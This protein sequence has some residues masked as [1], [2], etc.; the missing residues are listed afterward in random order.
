M[1]K[2]AIITFI[3][4]IL[5]L[6][7]LIFVSLNLGSI[8][9]TYSELFKGLFIEY[10]EKVASIYNIRFPRIFLCLLSGA[11]LSVSGVLFQTILKNPIADA[12][13][14]GVAS[15]ASLATV[16]ILTIFPTLFFLKPI[17]AF[18]GGIL[19]F[20]LILFLSFGK[21]LS[22]IK[23]I[24]IGIAINSCFSGIIECFSSMNSS[25]SSAISSNVSFKTWDDV[26]LMFWYTIVGLILALASF[27]FCDISALDDKT[28]RSLGFNTTIIK[29]ILLFIAVILSSISTAVVGI[30]YFLGLIVPHIS[31]NLVGSK[32]SILLPFS[33]V[34]GAFI[35]LLA[36]TLGRTII[37][38][39][40]IPA[41]VLMNIVGGIAFIII[42]RKSGKVYGN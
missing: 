37:S 1:N 5:S 17:F 39:Y 22:G 28:A 16:I 25:I 29:I 10:N 41:S 31:R 27:K 18:I 26:N 40:E 15:G 11:A 38:P 19:T 8:K 36:D 14:L 42:L 12:S 32:H 4:L 3:L 6:F 30:I 21:G 23:I 20:A 24:L 2:R 7:I 34:L 35:M 33:M 13:L 9:V